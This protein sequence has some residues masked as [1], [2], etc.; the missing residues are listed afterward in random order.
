MALDNIKMHAAEFTLNK[1]K[2]ISASS[3]NTFQTC[4]LQWHFNYILKLIQLPNPNFIVG[5]AYH[6]C[7][8]EFHSGRKPEQIIKELKKDLLEEKTDE[9]I[10]RFGMVRKMFEKYIKDPVKGDILHNEYRFSLDIEGIDVPL[11]GFVDRVDVDKIVEY[12]TSS[13]DYKQENVETIQS[14][15]YT[16]AI[17]RE[18]GKIYPVVYSINNKKKINN[19]SYKP[20]TMGIEYTVD[21][22]HE[23]EDY[24]RGV[25]TDMVNTKTFPHNKSFHCNW[26][27]FGKKGTGNCPYS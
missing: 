19:S 6:K 3:V 10:Q 23:L 14:K 22:M 11:V 16:Y 20:Q 9:A 21:D 1:L 15:I 8:E 25:Y 7:L 18:T 4:K 24:L 17:W 2:R 13:F 27:S 26:C 12:K 5:T